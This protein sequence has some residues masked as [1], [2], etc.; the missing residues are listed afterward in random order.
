MGVHS[1]ASPYLAR[2]AH[3]WETGKWNRA[4]MAHVRHAM[5]TKRVNKVRK[6][7]HSMALVVEN[8][9]GLMEY[10]ALVVELKCV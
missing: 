8:R 5:E 2:Y 7:L 10:R 3:W 4:L 9:A 6:T 1:N